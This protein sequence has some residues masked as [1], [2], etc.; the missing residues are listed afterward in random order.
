M[1]KERVNLDEGFGRR[2]GWWLRFCSGIFMD[3]DRLGRD[4]F[5]F[6]G[7]FFWDCCIVR[8][9]ADVFMVGRYLLMFED[10]NNSNNNELCLFMYKYICI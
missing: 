6:F 8:L 7:F 4:L 10:E 1:F 2:V 5:V 3:L 9:C